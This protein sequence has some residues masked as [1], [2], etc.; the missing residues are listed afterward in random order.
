MK[1]AAMSAMPGDGAWTSPT[2]KMSCAATSG[3]GDSIGRSTTSMPLF[4]V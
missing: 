1:L 3:I 4:I 2:S